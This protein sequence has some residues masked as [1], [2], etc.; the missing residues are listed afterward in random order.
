MAD[1][2]LTNEGGETFEDSFNKDLWP[3]LGLNVEKVLK[4]EYKGQET[5]VFQMFRRGRSSDS[6]KKDSLSLLITV[7]NRLSSLCNE[8][9]S[10]LEKKAKC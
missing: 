5:T 1:I 2:R 7:Q 9:A 4:G 3:A 6:I 8:I 10:K